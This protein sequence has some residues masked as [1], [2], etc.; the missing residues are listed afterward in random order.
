MNSQRT[1]DVTDDT[2]GLFSSGWSII[3][4][5]DLTRKSCFTRFQ[6]GGKLLSSRLGLAIPTSS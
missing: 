5:I 2:E 1:T 3:A 4:A 6:R